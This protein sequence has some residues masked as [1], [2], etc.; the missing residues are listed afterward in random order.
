M[1]VEEIKNE[2]RGSWKSIAPE[3][4][5]SALK[6]EDGS[7]KPFYLTREFEYGDNDQFK[8]VII[9]SADPYGQ[10]PIARISIV[11]HIAWAGGH[12]IAPDAQKV[13][14]TADEVYEV[15]PLIQGFADILNKVATEGY[16]KWEVGQSQSV[17]GK[18][19]LP[20]GLV[21]G[22]YFK[23]FDLIYVFNDFLFWGARNV[24]GRGFDTAENRPTNLQIPL[25]R[26]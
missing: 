19:F 24:D 17:F 23:E 1:T 6:N 7:A 8:L 9:N 26:R 18:A 16:D 4:R 14:F 12:P 3:I 10:V 11:G 13:D 20:F 5:P 25:V 2:I 22:Q 21:E 15:A